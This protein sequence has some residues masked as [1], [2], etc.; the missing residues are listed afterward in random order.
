DVT[1]ADASARAKL[2]QDRAGQVDRHR[3]ADTA[4]AGTDR[5]V[6][7]DDLAP[8]V[9]ERAAAVAEID[10]RV[11]LNVAVEARVEELPAD[12]ADHADGDAVLVA[13]GIADRD[14]PFTHAERRGIAERRHRE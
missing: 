13:Q 14:D 6:D 9:D 10:G 11:G 3:E 8:R 12:V 5:G 1:A 4:A 7:P 2:R